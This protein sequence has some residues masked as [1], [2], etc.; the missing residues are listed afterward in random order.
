MFPQTNETTGLS[1]ADSSGIASS[2][3]SKYTYRVHST[4]Y[5]KKSQRYCINLQRSL[6]SR[7]THSA[8]VMTSADGKQ[9]FLGKKFIH[10]SEQP[11]NIHEMKSFIINLYSTFI[12]HQCHTIHLSFT[13]PPHPP[14][15]HL[16]TIYN[17]IYMDLCNSRVFVLFSSRLWCLGSDYCHHVQTKIFHRHT[18][19]ASTLHSHYFGFFLNNWTILLTKLHY[20]M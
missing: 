15:R 19:L 12:R 9:V 10:I 3:K 13:H 16:S 2:K 11:D 17:Q 4:L 14:V 5:F 1:S 20:F 6:N 8:M 18:I 7:P